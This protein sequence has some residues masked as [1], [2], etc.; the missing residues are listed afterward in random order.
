MF[1]TR[2]DID[3]KTD[4]TLE[5]LAEHYG[6]SSKAAV[7]RKAIALLCVAKQYE[8]PEGTLTLRGED[9]SD[10]TISLR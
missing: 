3:G 8:S 1:V 6:A 4:K 2:F 5:K 7:L 9:G 10:I